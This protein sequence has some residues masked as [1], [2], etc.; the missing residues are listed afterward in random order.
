MSRS[1]PHAETPMPPSPRV[2]APIIVDPQTLAGLPMSQIIARVAM[3]ESA[4]RESEDRL[5]LLVDAVTEYSIFTL[6]PDGVIE[7]WNTG[8]ERMKGYSHD[9]AMGLDFSMLFPPAD[10]E[11]G[12][13]RQLLEQARAHGSHKHTGWLLKKDGTL[14]WSDVVINSMLDDRGHHTGFV[15]VVR[16]LT[17][18]H[19]LEAAQNSFYNAFNHEF[20]MPITAIQGF[21][22]LLTDVDVH[23]QE[24]FVQRIESNTTRLLTMVEE[25]IDNARLRPGQLPIRLQVVDL[26]ALVRRTVSELATRAEIS[27]VRITADVP[28]R[29]LADP[30]AMER[31]IANLVI[32]ALTDS[33]ANSDITIACEPS[34]DAVVV[35]ISDQGRGTVDR[36]LGSIFLEFERGRVA[37]DHDAGSGLGLASVQRLVDIQG[38]TVDLVSDVAVGTTVTI[39]LPRAPA[40]AP[41]QPHAPDAVPEQPPRSRWRSP[42]L[43]QR[44]RRTQSL[45]G[46]TRRGNAGADPPLPADVGSAAHRAPDVDMTPRNAA[47]RALAV[48]LER[49]HAAPDYALPE[50]FSQYG[51]AIGVSRVVAYLADLQ[52][53]SLAPLL[54][55]GVQ[56]RA[57]HVD[58]LSVDRTIAGRAFQHLEVVQQVV[59]DDGSTDERLQ[60]WLPLVDGTERL[61]VLAVTLPGAHALDAHG[62]ALRE[63]LL[64]FASVAA[65][66]IASKTKHGDTLVRLRRTR[67][68]SLAAE[69]QW[70][71]LPPLAFVSDDV[72]ITGGVEP[73]YGVGGD[74]IDYAVDP[75]LAHLAVFDAM[76]HGL[77]SAQLSALTV[78]AYRNA[79][80]G[81]LGLPA[82]A[83]SIDTAVA[84]VFGADAFATGVVVQLDTE[85]G[86]LRWINA[87]HPAP[88]LL[89]NGRLVRTLDVEPMLPF[90]LGR[91]AEGQ[92]VHVGQ[93]RLEP[94]DMVLLHSDG[95]VEARSIRGA[96]F[97]TDRLVE[98]LTL[99]LAAGLPP[100]ETMRRVTLALLEH[101]HDKLSDDVS[102]LL[103]Q[104]RPQ[105][106]LEQR[107]VVRRE[108]LEGSSTQ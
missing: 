90:G 60:V 12:R 104:Y 48:L 13:P 89:R 52:A 103:L 75:G 85:T 51:Q 78:S 20:K 49:S 56:D 58:V 88:L 27:R 97:G 105:P 59:Q 93:E 77:P 95:V 19:R 84:S 63:R 71:L 24:H 57:S 8:A 40:A 68:M 28:M 44:S 101:H 53:R 66:L 38:G 29:A 106:R 2:A 94:G 35:T 10:R 26:A 79:R 18:Q 65:E 46:G 81:G 15:K 107:R 37:N 23:E 74:T 47:E 31:V 98:L 33:P 14:L 36:D 16:D 76:G 82:L 41:E 3:L 99:H 21:A 11:A 39:R 42:L 1:E 86:V 6:D 80:R 54:G 55:P 43:R 91:L 5:R 87:G 72:T 34:E 73:A 30:A 45:T 25:L 22:E 102:F 9:E 69:M 61:G 7:S 70:S 67:D 83:R 108:G 92:G 96:F 64:T 100:T 32:K 62:G 50:L 17:E 4:L